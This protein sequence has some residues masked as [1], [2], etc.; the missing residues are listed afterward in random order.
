MPGARIDRV[1]GSKS[2]PGEMRSEHQVDRDRI[3]YS[4][5]FRRLAGVTQVV[6]PGEGEVFHNRL[7]HSLKVAQIARRFAED[8]QKGQ[9]DRAESWG[10]I[11]ADVVEAAA[12]A[13]DLGHPPFGHIAEE[14]LDRLISCALCDEEGVDPKKHRREGYEGNAQ[15]F[16]I[17]T[18]LAIRGPK[19]K[20]GLDLTRATLNAALKY[21]W[22]WRQNTDKP[23]KFGAYQLD[24]SAY[25]FARHGE[26]GFRRSLEAQ[27]MDWSDDIAYS[28]HDTEDF[29]R[30]GLI[31][32]DR[33]ASGTTELTKFLVAVNARAERHNSDRKVDAGIE[34]IAKGL[35]AEFKIREPYEGTRE[36]QQ[37]LYEFVSSNIDKYVKST[38]FQD[39]DSVLGSKGI[40]V[41]YSEE[42]ETE[43]FLLKELIWVYVIENPSLAA[44]QLGQRR[45]IQM[46]FEVFNTA[47][48]DK[49]WSLFPAPFRE[50]A[51]KLAADF[52][53]TI[54]TNS[55]VRLVSDTISSMTDKQ[56]LIIYQQFTGVSISSML[57]PV[58]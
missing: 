14:E 3:L 6:S 36:Q 10:G 53:E 48:L 33:L 15:S 2:K 22:K 54:P 18:D 57:K 31:P 37:Y 51:V 1:S 13:H 27:I 38:E 9:A 32:L 43:I 11:N 23:K 4:M 12:L 41:S 20:C 56:A 25:A 44:H 19:H 17:I 46:L 58:M 55:R 8:F 16:R 30:A 29:Y 52:G 26:V 45:A 24:D 34:S 40:A 21:P 39:S 47:I 28:I 49:E 7:T 50:R 5:A 35:F 42:I